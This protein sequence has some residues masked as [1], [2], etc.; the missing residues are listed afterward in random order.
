MA[1]YQRYAPDPSYSPMQAIRRGDAAAQ[2]AQA[3]IQK[4][5]EFFNS[6]RTVDQQRIEDARF[7]GQ[8]LE[9]L[10]KLTKAGTELYQQKA[11]QEAKDIATGQAYDLINR[12]ELRSPTY[13]EAALLEVDKEKLVTHT[14]AN[15]LD[16]VGDTETAEFL[17]ETYGG[18][19]QGKVN[20]EVEAQ[21][22]VT[23]FPSDVQAILNSDRMV[24]YNGTAVPISQLY[25]SEDR[26]ARQYALDKAAMLVLE[27]NNAQFWTK[28]T[29]VNILGNTIRTTLGYMGTAQTTAIVN[30]QKEEKLAQVK[31]TGFN[32]GADSTEGNVTANYQQLS[33]TLYYDNNGILTREKAN[34]V[35]AEVFL[36]GAASVSEDQVKLVG[37]ALT[38][39]N[40]VGTEL[41]KSNPIEY[42][43][44]IELARGNTKKRDDAFANDV[45][46]KALADIQSLPPGDMEGRNRRL[47]EAINAL[48]ERGMMQKALELAGSAK[49]YISTPEQQL[50]F[51]E[52]QKQQASGGGAVQDTQLQ[53]LVKNGTL[54]P[55]QAMQLRT[56]RTS[57]YN[58]PLQ[59]STAT[60]TIFSRDF[61][62][63]L[64]LATGSTVDQASGDFKISAT[65]QP[66][67]NGDNMK[68]I[69]K[70]Y[71]KAL[72]ADLDAYALTLDPSLSPSELN[73]LMEKRA[74]AFYK[75]NVE[76]AN[77]RFYLGG[78]FVEPNSKVTD[79]N[80]LEYQRVRQAGYEFNQVSLGNVPTAPTGGKDY[81]GRWNPGQGVSQD[82]KQAY[83]PG[84]R[85]LSQN[86]AMA[87]RL[88]AE[89]GVFT[90]TTIQAA[91]DLN[92]TP[93]QFIDQQVLAS[94]LPAINWNSPK[95]KNLDQDQFALL[96][97]PAMVA[98]N[99]NVKPS[100]NIP[101]RTG[102]RSTAIIGMPIFLSRGLSVQGAS[103]LTAYFY[104]QSAKTKTDIFNQKD[105][106]DKALAKLTPQ[107]LAYLQNPNVTY[108][109]LANWFKDPKL[110]SYAKTFE[111]LYGLN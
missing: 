22:L 53:E 48:E 42:Q 80:T 88:D 56:Q 5:Q 12:P 45:I 52:L 33:D 6:N 28:D 81:S 23:T 77:G 43:N 96:Q 104:L 49:V 18:L 103:I 98:L 101:G 95:L 4:M 64:A 29:L 79:P 11:L 108:R 67:I 7:E 21:R 2:R 61:K 109:D 51:L 35:A 66:P 25:N 91:R 58:K 41:Y 15:S 92:L 107:Q 50:K 24:R 3:E 14:G 74:Q 1:D 90:V 59:S 38:N 97:S 84:D 39:P 76:N 86:E 60:V 83:K 85:L 70:A 78:L 100:D 57:L 54:M 37:R 65:S 94:R 32:R 10:A 40:Q 69:S 105:F 93:K 8:N 106:A 89:Q 55:E 47:Q 73:E 31:T 19:Q 63:N 27:N 9:A 68:T 62:G 111:K 16:A 82:I 17:R 13:E 99:Q 26:Q 71:E 30:Q 75:K 44:A 102:Y 36:N 72:K 20:E 34:R 46:Q 87:A 110:A